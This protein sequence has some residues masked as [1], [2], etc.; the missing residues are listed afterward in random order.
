MIFNIEENRLRYITKRTKYI[1]AYIGAINTDHI[2][3]PGLAVKS[4]SNMNGTA[5]ISVSELPIPYDV[6]PG[7][8]PKRVSATGNIINIRLATIE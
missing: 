8:S 2:L 3:L 7:I 1:N 4:C 6:A 5:I